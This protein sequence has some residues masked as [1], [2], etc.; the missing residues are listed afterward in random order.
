MALA[1]ADVFGVEDDGF[2]LAISFRKVSFVM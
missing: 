2:K 1:V